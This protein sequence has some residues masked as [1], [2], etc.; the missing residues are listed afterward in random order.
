MKLIEHFINNLLGKQ[1]VNTTHK[2]EN[3]MVSPVSPVSE[4][5]SYSNRLRMKPMITFRSK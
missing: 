5:Q 3:M 1:V 4:V 2:A